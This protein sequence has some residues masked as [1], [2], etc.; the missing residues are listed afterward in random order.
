MS[1]MTS[2]YNA[3]EYTSYKYF[4]EKNWD[5]INRSPSTKKPELLK[6][7]WEFHKEFY[8]FIRVDL[9]TVL[10]IKDKSVFFDGIDPSL[11]TVGSNQIGLSYLKTE[12][13]PKIESVSI[14]T[15]KKTLKTQYSYTRLTSIIDEVSTTRSIDPN[16]I[17]AHDA[18]LAAKLIEAGA[19][20]SVHDSFGINITNQHTIIEEACSYFTSK[21]NLEVR[22]IF[23]LL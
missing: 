19:F 18:L 2:N 3:E 10:F 9:F 4:L 6:N 11:V 1:I 7:L 22:S 14:K 8:K 20:Y 16:L 13:S 12:S 17:Q 5:A 23:I 15:N 21:L